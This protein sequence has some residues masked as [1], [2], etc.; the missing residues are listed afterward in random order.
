MN[1][2]TTNAGCSKLI[3]IVPSVIMSIFLSIWDIISAPIIGEK[4][5]RL[6]M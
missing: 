6:Q 1:K 5:Y 2:I 4:I 3:G